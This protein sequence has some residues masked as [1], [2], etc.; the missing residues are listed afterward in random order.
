MAE[1]TIDEILEWLDDQDAY[2]ELPESRDRVMRKAIVAILERHKFVTTFDDAQSKAV[3]LEAIRA[4][5][6]RVE[7]QVVETRWYWDRGGDDAERA[8]GVMRDEL[9][10]MEKESN[11]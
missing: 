9:A 11:G 10:A 4:F 8:I 3:Q 2:A 5:V 7:K 1:P 6:E